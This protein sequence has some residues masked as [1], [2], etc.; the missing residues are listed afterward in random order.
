MI[1]VCRAGISPWSL[2]TSL[3]RSCNKPGVY[4]SVAVQHVQLSLHAS[5]SLHSW[6]LTCWCDAIVRRRLQAG[7]A[8]MLGRLRIAP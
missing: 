2:D 8:G 6:C 5:L 3:G 4:I 7:L 1:S